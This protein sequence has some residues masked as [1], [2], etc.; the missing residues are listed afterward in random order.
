MT[1]DNLWSSADWEDT[2]EEANDELL[3]RMVSRLGEMPD[4]F[5]EAWPR[6]EDFL[7]DDGEELPDVDDDGNPL[8][9]E[10]EKPRRWEGRLSQVLR[11]QKPHG[12]GEEEVVAFERFME[13][14]LK[15]LPEE[16]AS[17][18]ELLTSE[19]LTREWMEEQV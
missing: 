16:R 4:R 14:C 10:E 6:K 11:K 3:M 12:M 1:L 19:W 17:A 18:E 9:E 2:E 5:R 8:P 13:M 7:D 15:W